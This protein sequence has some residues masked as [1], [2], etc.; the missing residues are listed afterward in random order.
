[1]SP[2]VTLAARSPVAL[3]INRSPGAGVAASRDTNPNI[4][5]VGLMEGVREYPIVP[6]YTQWSIFP[7]SKGGA[8]W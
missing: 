8:N 4:K 6:T 1:M 7:Y 2:V 5:C 3:V